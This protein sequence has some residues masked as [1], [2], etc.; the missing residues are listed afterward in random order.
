MASLARPIH[1][2][3]CAV[4]TTTSISMLHNKG[5]SILSHGTAFVSSDILLGILE[6]LQ[7]VLEIL[8]SL[9]DNPSRPLEMYVIILTDMMYAPNGALSIGHH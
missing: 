5:E 2:H 6:V 7:I 4:S 9:N 3:H 8:H 1:T